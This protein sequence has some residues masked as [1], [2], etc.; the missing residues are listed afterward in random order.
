MSK[1]VLCCA[2]TVATASRG[3]ITSYPR[4]NAFKA[5]DRIHSSVQDPVS[6]IVS[7]S[8]AFIISSKILFP[9]SSKFQNILRSLDGNAIASSSGVLGA[10]SGK[11]SH[12]FSAKINS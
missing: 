1:A 5:V 6:T 11:M 12:P 10:I 9:L 3:M 4:L 2:V 7:I 8:R